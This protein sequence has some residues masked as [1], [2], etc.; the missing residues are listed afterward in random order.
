MA[1][2][3]Q[4]TDGSVSIIRETDGQEV[5]RAGGPKT[6][7][8]S[9]PAYMPGSVLK[10]PVTGGTDTAGG[11]LAWQNTLGYDILVDAATLDVTTQS[12]GACTVSI[13]G[14]ANGATLNAGMISGQSVA[15]TGTFGKAT[16]VAQ[17]VAANAFITASTASGASAALI[18]NV[19]VSFFPA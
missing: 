8:A 7:S 13:G 14:A 4:N 16:P 18:G 17:K 15:A 12:S 19:Y 1:A 11:L 6:V 5:F 9:A 3:K 2:L 10:L